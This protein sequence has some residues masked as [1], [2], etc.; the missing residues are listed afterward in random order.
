MCVIRRPC[1][2]LPHYCCFSPAL[3]VLSLSFPARMLVHMG[4]TMPAAL[5]ATDC[6]HP[7]ITL[8]T[9]HIARTQTSSFAHHTSHA[10]KHHTLHITHRTHAN[11]TLCTSHIARTQTSYFAHH[12]SHARK[13]HTLHITHR[14]HENII[15]CTSHIARTKKS[16]FAHHTSHAHNQTLCALHIART[17]ASHFTHHTNHTSHARNQTLCTHFAHTLHIAHRTL[18]PKLDFVLCSAKLCCAVPNC[19]SSVRA[20]FMPC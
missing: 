14:T 3:T 16:R 12:T 4:F 11:I 8:C 7:N 5:H 2:L 1:A 15:L 6:T 9:S 18:R 17:Q 20:H 13:H 10:R 19:T